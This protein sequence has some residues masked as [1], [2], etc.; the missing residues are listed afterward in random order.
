MKKPGNAQS[1]VELMIILAVSLVILLF[2]LSFGFQQA[3]T[4]DIQKQLE[5]AK[6]SANDLA[7]AA[8]DVYAQGFGARKQVLVTIPNGTD[9]SK[10][11]IENSTIVFNVAGT[12]LFA[13][14]GVQLSGSF[15]TTPG[16]HL[17]WVESRGS[18]VSIGSEEAVLDTYSVSLSMLSSSSAGKT[19][20]ITNYS[21]G[22]AIATILPVWSNPDVSLSLSSANFSIP[23][24]SA[25]TFDTN[26]SSGASAVGAYTGSV[27]VNVHLS[28]Y[29]QNIVVPLSVEVSQQ[30]GTGTT[31][32]L[33][34]LPSAWTAT[35]LR[36]SSSVKTFNVC[37]DSTSTMDS[38]TFTPSSGDA[39]DFAQPI[40]PIASI[41]A[42]ECAT[43]DINL[44]VP[45]LQ[46]T[47]PYTGTINVSDADGNS[48]SIALTITVV[49]A[50][51]VFRWAINSCNWGDCNSTSSVTGAPDI[52]FNSS[53]GNS[54]GGYAFD[55]SGLSGNIVAL[56][57]LWSHEVSTPSTSQSSIFETTS[58]DFNEGTESFSQTT[59]THIDNGEVALSAKSGW[60]NSQWNYR[61]PV[62]LT[63]NRGV[64][65]S[66][67]QTN[68]TLSFDASHI[69]SCA[70]EIRVITDA[71]VEIPVRILSDNGS[72]PVSP[73][74]KI[75]FGVTISANNSAT[76]H[77]YYGNS[78]AANPGYSIPNYSL[79][80]L[81]SGANALPTND[82][83]S[84]AVPLFSDFLD[85]DSDFD[86]V[87]GD[88]AGIFNNVWR[89][90]GTPSSPSWTADNAQLPNTDV[91]S[92][93]T[94]AFADLDNDGDKDLVVGENTGNI[95]NG[96]RNTGTAAVPAWQAYSWNLPA[97]DFGTDSSPS[98]VDIDNDNNF[99]L[100]IGL[101]DGTI[102]FLRN[103]GTPSAPSWS[104]VSGVMPSQD[105]GSNAAP[106][107]A[108]LDEDGDFDLIVGE[109]TGRLYLVRNIGSASSPSW[110]TVSLSNYLAQ[111]DG[112]TIDVGTRAAPFLVDLDADSYRDLVIGAGNGRLQ[113]NS[114]NGRFYYNSHL[115]ISVGAEESPYYFGG[116]YTSNA[117]DFGSAVT[118]L[119]LDF[120]STLNSQSLSL[121]FRT[122]A[123][124]ITWTDWSEPRI[125]TPQEVNDENQFIQYIAYFSG[126]GAGTA[127]LNDV[128]ITVQSIGGMLDDSVSLTYGLSSFDQS[129]ALTYD[130]LNTPANKMSTDPGAIESVDV[131]SLRPG[132]G[133]WQWS[134]F[135][136]LKIGGIYNRVGSANGS[137]RLDAV[138]VEISYG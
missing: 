60:W 24:G 134:D 37:N 78:S 52:S 111:S 70:N 48:D 3:T 25:L 66:N 123:D 86:L 101:S 68:L 137:W 122:S 113:T 121:S 133:A 131:F 13:D 54:L 11:G 116:T 94:P 50:T 128:N 41:A 126:N 33:V 31:G 85:A 95:N 87:V 39:G 26:F 82:I 8:K 10:T 105:F 44:F 72:N 127:Y 135:S 90:T 30:G 53:N 74:C 103:T 69:D 5:T 61:L 100:A 35:I 17:V 16:G 23:Q 97:T 18:Y 109:S 59:L 93:S 14:P 4:I 55:V 84:N 40:S 119:S 98:F 20:T 112:A 88:N 7:N 124:G 80:W 118:I 19:I 107:F 114:S 36:G 32:A 110:E 22:E 130:Y 132:G 29:D 46:A 92:N 67:Q 129:T 56:N 64:S 51:T 99:D 9:E 91:G 2:F 75:Q 96:W 34:V 57:I 1:S 120:N 117:L 138:G 108:D 28:S 83:G 77:V 47:G 81:D 45:P 136:N 6:T 104:Q 49:Q 15:P 125:T 106:T 27:Q 65:R 21:P 115:N 71:N 42:G 12:D 73:S 38:I 79:T 62:L 58:A 63:E 43:A 89:N 76:Y 102:A